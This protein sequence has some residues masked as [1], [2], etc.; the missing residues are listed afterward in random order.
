MPNSFAV[1]C[2]FPFLILLLPACEQRDAETTETPAQE[3]RCMLV[4]GWDPWEPYQYRDARGEVTGLDVE[5]AR[6]AAKAGGCSV[7]FVA[8]SWMELLEQVQAGDVHLLAGATMTAGR[9]EFAEFTPPYRKETFVVYT[10]AG[11]DALRGAEKLDDLL[12]GD[13]RVGT[14]AEYYYGSEI[15]ATLD[16]LQLADRL[17]EAP[18]A[19]LNYDRLELGEIDALIDDPYVASSVLRNHPDATF[20]TAT[21][22]QVDSG[23]VA[24]MLSRTGVEPAARQAFLDG[25]ETVRTDGTLARILERWGATY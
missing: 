17:R 16:T 12:A 22:I 8:A 14:V 13:T 7:E 23:E 11:N 15:A 25:L 21:R 4:M 18:V 1:R 10:H 6:A 5:I 24:F 9:E 2:L 19:S 20:I 3:P